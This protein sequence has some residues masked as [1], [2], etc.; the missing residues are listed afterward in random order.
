MAERHPCERCGKYMIL[1]P[2][3]ALCQRDDAWKAHPKKDLTGTSMSHG[4]N[5]AYIS[6]CKCLECKKAHADYTKLLTHYGGNGRPQGV[7]GHNP[8]SP[9]LPD[10]AEPIPTVSLADFEGD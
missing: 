10:W 8:D 3:C 7:L 4:T 9:K 5:S 2:L 1:L 6:G